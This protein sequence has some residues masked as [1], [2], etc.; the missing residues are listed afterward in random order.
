MSENAKLKVEALEALVLEGGKGLSALSELARRTAF[1]WPVETERV[2][3]RHSIRRSFTFLLDNGFLKTNRA[4]SGAEAALAEWLRGEYDN[5][6]DF[7][8]ECVWSDES[9]VADSLVAMRTLFWFCGK[10]LLVGKGESGGLRVSVV[11]EFIAS[12]LAQEGAINSLL[13][14]ALKDEYLCKYVDFH[15]TF[16]K[17][18]ARLCKAKQPNWKPAYALI[19]LVPARP[20]PDVLAVGSQEKYLK[21]PFQTAWLAF[22]SLRPNNAK[23]RRQALGLLPDLIA[24]FPQPQLLCDFLTSC[25]SAT[26]EDEAEI[27]FT[28]FS[29]LF[30]LVRDYQ[31]DYPDLYLRLYKLLDSFRVESQPQFGLLMDAC[32]K[33]SHLPLQLVAS[34]AKKLGRIALL[35]TS[36]STSV[37]ALAFIYNLLRRN[38]SLVVLIHSPQAAQD[39]LAEMK[40][41]GR[42]I[43][44]GLPPLQPGGGQ[45]DPFQFAQADY[46]QSGAMQSSLWEIESLKR[47]YCPSVSSFARSVFAHDL[48]KDRLTKQELPLDDFST[49]SG[50]LFQ[51]E[52]RMK[53][54]GSQPKRLKVDAPLNVQ[55]PNEDAFLSLVLFK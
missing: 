38:P 12:A 45:L 19:A 51:Q 48:A 47:H 36:P 28:A 53:G 5:Y 27:P 13:L 15:R 49:T 35:T 11:H 37:F 16:L 46:E 21:R 1:E 42:R 22:L 2:A 9:V 44:L 6:L 29:S 50:D 43:A 52:S 26:A 3:A 20:G 10:D 17:E 41:N 32:F 25:F 34:F 40:A 30:V 31:L 24:H 18:F 14:S 33:S 55:K 23:E 7:L 39:K 4:H 8:N 54:D